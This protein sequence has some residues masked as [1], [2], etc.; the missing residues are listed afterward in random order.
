M[1]VGGRESS[2]VIFDLSNWVE[3]KHLLRWELKFRE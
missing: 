1:G 2:V 3:G